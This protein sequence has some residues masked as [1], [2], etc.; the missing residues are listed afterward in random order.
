MAIMM[1]RRFS[2]LLL[3]SLCALFSAAQSNDFET[4]ASGT[5]KTD[6]S[7]KFGTSLQTQ[8]R[9]KNNSSELGTLFFEPDVVYKV[10]KYLRISAGYRF[11]LRFKSDNVNTTAHRCNLDMEGRKKFGNLRLKLRTRLQQGFTDLYYNENRKPYSY[12]L[13]NRNKFAIDYEVNKRF[14]PYAE[15]EVFLPL[16]DPRQRN[17]DRYRLTIGS[18]FDLKNR[19]AIDCFFRIQQERNTA[20]PQTAYILGV[21]YSY[22][23]KF[24]TKKK[25]NKEDK[26]SNI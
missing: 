9:L 7:K 16:N 15:F 24:D 5:L 3:F 26:Q 17:F 18:S 21:G 11:S 4:W 6:I 25:D 22:D 10:N 8:A 14:N 23:F 20:N 2:F 19:N 1:T 12:P 13:Y